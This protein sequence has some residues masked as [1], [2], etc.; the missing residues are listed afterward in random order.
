[1]DN[2]LHRPVS[3]N[4]KLRDLLKNPPLL[5]PGAHDGLTARLVEQ[6]G[7]D[8]VYMGGYASTGALLGRP[9]MGLLTGTEMIG[10]A[11]RLAGAVDI[12]VVADADTGY[13]N[14]INVVRTVHD[15]EQA[16]VSAIHLEDQTAPKRCGHLAG[17]EVI[18]TGEHV[19]KIKA[20]VTARS[21][22]DFVII[23]RTDALV[24]YGVEAACDRA[25]RY[26]DAGADVLWVEAPTSEAELETISKRL[27]GN[28]VLLNWLEG[29]LTPMIDIERIREYGFG[30]VLYP[31]GSVLA[32]TGAMRDHYASVRKHGTPLQ[33]MRTLPSF[34]DFTKAVGISEI[35]QLS[36]EFADP[37]TSGSQGH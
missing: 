22:P 26:R 9:D 4:A 19:G 13:G 29:G 32:V 36:Q 33:C 27:S 25:L 24:K 20:A 12:P 15:Y 8:A 37:D 10:H 6:A 16:G 30:V 34:D 14:A 2:F 35:E 21:D 28:T 31:I 23:A 7:F 1:M 17:K 5:V 3:R 11:R 18:V